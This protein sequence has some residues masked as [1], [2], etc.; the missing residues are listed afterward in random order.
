MANPTKFSRPS[1]NP[2]VEQR[3]FP[4]TEEGCKAAGVFAAEKQAAGF[5]TQFTTRFSHRDF[6]TKQKVKCHVVHVFTR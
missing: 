2:A 1:V 5:R 3:T 6:K 4:R